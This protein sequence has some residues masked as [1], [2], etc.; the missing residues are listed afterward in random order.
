MMDHTTFGNLR[1]QDY[2]SN[3]TV[4]YKVLGTRHGGGVVRELNVN[5]EF[6]FCPKGASI[7]V[8]GADGHVETKQRSDFEVEGS[9]RKLFEKGF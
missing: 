4:A 2:I 1:F 8:A 7:N 5:S 3:T 9:F 6:N